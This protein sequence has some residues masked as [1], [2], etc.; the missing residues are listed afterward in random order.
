MQHLNSTAATIV[1]WQ[2]ENKKSSIFLKYH[3]CTRIC[4]HQLTRKLFKFHVRRKE[5][6][7][8]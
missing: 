7:K 6:E 8:I 5:S 3:G 1:E 4:Q 2:T